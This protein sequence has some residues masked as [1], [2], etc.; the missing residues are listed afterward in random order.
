MKSAEIAS[1]LF[2]DDEQIKMIFDNAK[3]VEQY[4]SRKKRA[5]FYG[6][7]VSQAIVTINNDERNKMQILQKENDALKVK[8]RNEKQASFRKGFKKCQEMYRGYNGG[9]SNCIFNYMSQPNYLNCAAQSIQMA[10]AC[11]SSS[12]PSQPIPLLNIALGIY[13]LFMTL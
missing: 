11:T 2:Q 12:N 5:T 7:N 4:I 6:R 9:L 10:R 13:L 3:A 8:L 1:M